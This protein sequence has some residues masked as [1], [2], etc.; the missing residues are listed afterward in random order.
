MDWQ[1]HTLTVWLPGGIDARGAKIEGFARP[2]L[3]SPLEKDNIF[4]DARYITLRGLVFRDAANFAQRGGV[5]LGRGWHADHC[6]VEGNN[7]GGMSLNGDDIRRGPLHRSI[8]RVLRDQRIGGQQHYF[9]TASFGGTTGRDFR[10][11]GKAEGEIHE[12][13]PSARDSSQP[14]MKTPGRG[15]GWTS[16]TRTIRSPIRRFTETMG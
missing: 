6:T 16:I 9:R 11:R 15:S 1:F 10:R 12:H 8:Q 5:I 3:I 4:L 13:A 14:V 7:A 2:N